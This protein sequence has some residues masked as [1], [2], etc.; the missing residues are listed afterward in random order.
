MTFVPFTWQVGEYFL[1]YPHDVLT[2]FDEVLNQTGSEASQNAL[3]ALGAADGAKWNRMKHTLHS[4]ITGRCLFLR[5][6]GSNDW[7]IKSQ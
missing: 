6:G 5:S 1:A 2:I 4:R 3:A 7:F